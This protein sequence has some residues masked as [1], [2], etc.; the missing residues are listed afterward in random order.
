MVSSI[1]V[2]KSQRARRELL[3]HAP[4]L[5]VDIWCHV[6]VCRYLIVSPESAA[7]MSDMADE[8][9]SCFW[10]IVQEPS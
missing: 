1:R 8:R 10:V 6:A 3:K 7:A 9:L 4:K 2:P 5:L